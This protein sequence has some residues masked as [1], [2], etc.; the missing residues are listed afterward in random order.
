MF[1]VNRTKEGYPTQIR[2]NHHKDK[3]SKIK[4]QFYLYFS[5]IRNSFYM[6]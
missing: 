5:N 3:P 1:N 6:F 4:S 2:I